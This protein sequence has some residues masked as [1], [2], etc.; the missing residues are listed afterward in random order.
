VKIAVSPL[1]SRR[2]C[3]RGE[4]VKKEAYWHTS[5]TECG[6]E[7]ETFLLKRGCVLGG[8]RGRSGQVEG[9]ENS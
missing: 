7:K 3:E 6:R 2:G 1:R 8:G 5:A 9:V 4:G